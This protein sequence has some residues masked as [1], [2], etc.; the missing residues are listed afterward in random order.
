MAAA[1]TTLGFNSY[2]YKQSM[3]RGHF[4]YWNRAL[5]QKLSGE[6]Q[7][8]GTA[9]F[10]KLLGDFDVRPEELQGRLRPCDNLEIDS[11]QEHP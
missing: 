11:L 6:G 7:P 1:L 8:W 9:D 3:E 2:R 5:Q 4:P 10:D